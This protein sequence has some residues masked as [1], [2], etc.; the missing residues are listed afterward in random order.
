MSMA[1][2]SSGGS[3]TI[4]KSSKGGSMSIMKSSVEYYNCI[5]KETHDCS[6]GKIVVVIIS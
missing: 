3:T 6:Q 5:F 2:T 1:M 4:Q